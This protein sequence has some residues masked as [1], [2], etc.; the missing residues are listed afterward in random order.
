[1]FVQI[2][3][4]SLQGTIVSSLFH[5]CDL[6]F[7]ILLQ[8]H[9]LFSRT[10]STFSYYYALP[11]LFIA[12]MV[13]K[14]AF[15]KYDLVHKALKSLCP[16]HYF[17]FVFE[18]RVVKNITNDQYVCHEPNFLPQ[19]LKQR[20]PYTRKDLH[21]TMLVSKAKD[22]GNSDDTKRQY[23]KLCICNLFLKQFKIEENLNYYKQQCEPLQQ[24]LARSLSTPT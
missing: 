24:P 13:A 17:H 14:I 3:M 15:D 23:G 2:L 9:I 7:V 11:Y 21:Q 22:F 6:K 16:F 5:I 19:T 4:L 8:K 20:Q 18:Q 1:M 12:L 10:Y